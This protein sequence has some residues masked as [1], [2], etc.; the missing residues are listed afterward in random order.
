MIHSLST[1]NK[2]ERRDSMIAAFATI[3][4]IGIVL[5]WLLISTL[6]YD[7][8]MAASSE[9]PQLEEDEIFLDPELLLETHKSIRKPYAVSHDS[10]DTHIKG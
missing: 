3:L 6:H 10:I 8:K 7:E 4:A 5:A 2:S 1:M 9:N